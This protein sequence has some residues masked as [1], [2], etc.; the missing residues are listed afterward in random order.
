MLIT[1]EKHP[2]YKIYD[3]DCKLVP[4]VVSF[5]TKTCELSMYVPRYNLGGVVTEKDK[6]SKRLLPKL[7]TFTLNGAFAVDE[8]GNIIKS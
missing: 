1:A 8:K 2:K 7:V 5:N 4:Y 3:A 6:D